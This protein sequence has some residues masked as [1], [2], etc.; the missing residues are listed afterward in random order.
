MRIQHAHFTP[1]R[2]PLRRRWLSHRGTLGERRGWLI[3]LQTES[4]SGVGDCAPLPSAGT[5]TAAEAE[6]WLRRYCGGFAGKDPAILHDLLDTHTGIPPAVRCGLET[7]LI[8]LLAK[9]Q[10]ISIAQWLNP[11]AARA[12]EVNANLGALD[13]QSAERIRGSHGYSVIK[14]KLGMAPLEQELSLLLQAAEGLSEGVSLRLDANRA[15]TAGEAMQLLSVCES[16]PIESIEE[17]L[18]APELEALRQLQQDTAIPLALDESLKA[19][20]PE[21]VLR[22]P[23]VRRLTLKPMV[24][25]GLTPAMAWAQ[26]ARDAGMDAVVTTTVDSA[27]G[28]WAAVNLA[29]ALGS[30][31]EKLAHGLAT[32]EWLSKD[33]AAPPEIVQGRISLQS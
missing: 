6:A 24:M 9:Q 13:V 23:P 8:D 17:P 12:V 2:L 21:A 14:M 22:R 16:L 7:A 20:D 31:G 15:W 19:L 11:N 1:Y 27:I 26:R 29:A 32:S 25:G 33:V 4:Q 28:V 5:E 10:G 3:C 18:A 30:R